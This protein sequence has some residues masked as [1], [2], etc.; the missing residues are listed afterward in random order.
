MLRI[1]EGMRELLVELERAGVRLGLVTSKSRATTEMA[2]RLTGVDAHFSAIVC[3]E[4]TERN[5]PYP[6]PLL[7]A[8][9][10]LGATAGEAVYVG[11]S[12]YDLRAANAAGMRSV[13]VTWGV[14][15]EEALR[16]EQPDRLVAAVS[17]LREVLGLSLGAGRGAPPGAGG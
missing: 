8:L 1:Y 6:D 12:P 15:G 17:K 4:D 10:I 16:P 11:D 3:A 9:E 2:F 5:K 14:F 13:G 7:L